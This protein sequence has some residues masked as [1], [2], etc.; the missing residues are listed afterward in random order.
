MSSSSES[1][2]TERF[3]EVFCYS[4]GSWENE[5]ENEENEE[6]EEEVEENDNDKRVQVVFPPD[7]PQAI[8]TARLGETERNGSIAVHA[9]YETRISSAAGAS[10]IGAETLQHA[11][12]PP[13]GQQQNEQQEPYSRDNHSD[14]HHNSFVTP[15]NDFDSETSSFVPVN[16]MEKLGIQSIASNSEHASNSTWSHIYNPSETYLMEETASNASFISDFDCLDIGGL[17]M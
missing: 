16:R 17:T 6:R 1:D 10:A 4:D 2:S 13:S 3:E 12:A 9:N 8:S 11:T 7:F 5:A 15:H 14:N